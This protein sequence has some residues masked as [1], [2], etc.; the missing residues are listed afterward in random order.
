MQKKL[1][2]FFAT[3]PEAT[4]VYTALGVLFTDPEKAKQFLRGVHGQEVIKH[5]KPA[6]IE[7]EETEAADETKSIEE[8]ISTDAAIEGEE[9]VSNKEVKNP[10][11]RKVAAPSK[12]KNK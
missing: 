12:N 11:K 10:A 9:T 8:K 4:E 1:N 5:L 6:T 7:D 3:H 2:N